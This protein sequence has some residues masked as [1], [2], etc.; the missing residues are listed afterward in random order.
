MWNYTK[1]ARI[2]IMLKFNKFMVVLMFS[3]GTESWTM[4]IR[5]QM[6]VQV[7]QIKFLKSVKGAVK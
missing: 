7:G 3:Y 4:K 2:E 5:D 6:R 1:N